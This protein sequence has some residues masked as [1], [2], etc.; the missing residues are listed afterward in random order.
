[1]KGEHGHNVG[2]YQRALHLI[3]VC[4]ST[5]LFS[6]AVTLAV[7]SPRFDE[8]AFLYAMIALFLSK[9]AEVCLAT[10]LA[11]KEGRAL[12]GMGKALLIGVAV[13]VMPIVASIAYNYFFIPLYERPRM[14]S[15]LDQSQRFKELTAN[16]KASFG[17]TVL[18]GQSR[19]DNVQRTH[20]FSP[21]FSTTTT[22]YCEIVINPRLAAE[23]WGTQQGELMILAHEF[24]HCVDLTRFERDAMSTAARRVVPPDLRSKLTDIEGVLALQDDRR[25]EK[26]HEVYAD[27]FAVGYAR[28][29]LAQGEASEGAKQLIA[30]RSKG[31]NDFAHQTQCWLEIA[32]VTALP[33]KLSDLAIW[34]DQ[35]RESAA[36][37]L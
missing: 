32:S 9:L 2:P 23:Y 7:T 10:K 6:L 5:I 28:M 20:S 21:A 3:L 31:K 8:P 36:C 30:K 22:N 37:P 19:V 26:W 33:A 25:V 24:G 18:S 27:I 29:Q 15:Y 13:L 11:E 4:L 16:A 17:I 35:L 34:S 12:D 1:M 14:V